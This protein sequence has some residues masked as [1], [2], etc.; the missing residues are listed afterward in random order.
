VE[1]TLLTHLDLSWNNLGALPLPPPGD[2]GW[3]PAQPAHGWCTHTK[4]VGALT[5]Y[6]VVYAAVVTCTL[7]VKRRGWR[8]AGACAPTAA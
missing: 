6:F 4:A 2:H 7:Q 1:G 8:W 5:T 3:Q